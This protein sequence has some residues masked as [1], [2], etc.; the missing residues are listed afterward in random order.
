MTD[1]T[2]SESTHLNA[3]PPALAGR[4]AIVTGGASG[5]G[6][7]IVDTFAAQGAQVVILDLD[8]AAAEASGGRRASGRGLAL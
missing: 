6:A 2:V 1:P 4:V 3:T 7:A 5:I 8:A